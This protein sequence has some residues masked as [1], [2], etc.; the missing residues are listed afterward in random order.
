M[1]IVGIAKGIDGK[2]YYITKNSWGIENVCGGYIYLS[3]DYVKLKTM[4]VLVN[5]DVLKLN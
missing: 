2:N 4:S 3:E 5:R 1:H